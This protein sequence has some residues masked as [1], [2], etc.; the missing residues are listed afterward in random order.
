MWGFRSL[1]L[2]WLNNRMATLIVITNVEPM[3][4]IARTT[5][6]SSDPAV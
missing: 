2:V 5:R 4:K 1:Y 6:L 3:D